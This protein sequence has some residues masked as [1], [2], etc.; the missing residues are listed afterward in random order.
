[1]KNKIVI[2]YP[3]NEEESLDVVI[4][5]QAGIHNFL[6]ESTTLD[7]RFRGNDNRQ[8]VPIRR[9]NSLNL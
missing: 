2:P 4:P 3:Y 5:A 9:L 1:M 7:S 6:Y 8:F